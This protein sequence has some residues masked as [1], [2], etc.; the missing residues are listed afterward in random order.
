[1]IRWYLLAAGVLA[2]D[3]ATKWIA[4]G[5][6]ERGMSV[7]V[8]PFLSWTLTC[9]TGAAFSMFQG[10]SWV[11]AVAAVAVS[12]FLIFEI[13]RLPRNERE[14]E[15]RGRPGFGALRSGWLE[16]ASYG[17]VLAGALGNLT[18]RLIHE[19]VVDF[20][21]VHYGWFNFPVFNVADSAI[22]VGAAG[23][24]GLLAEDMFRRRT[25]RSQSP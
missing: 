12:A 25:G 18:D 3:Q 10:Y 5:Q 21:H 16:G 6:L 11:F 22:T 15:P 24:I 17:L 14:R 19:C 8:L 2:L 9:N 20:I 23:W 1:M 7:D 13:W 4:L